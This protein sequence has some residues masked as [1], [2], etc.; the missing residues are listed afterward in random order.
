VPGV[1]QPAVRD[2]RGGLFQA[3]R[4]NAEVVALDVIDA[5]QSLCQVPLEVIRVAADDDRQ[6]VA[7]T[8]DG[9][10]RG[11]LVVSGDLL[12]DGR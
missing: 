6:Q 2:Q 9:D 4:A 3:L 1:N 5:G 11:D 10:N 12:G 7:A 8:T